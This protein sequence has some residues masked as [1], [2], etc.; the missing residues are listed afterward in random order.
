MSE[1][2]G[3]RKTDEGFIIHVSEEIGRLKEGYDYAAKGYETV[4][5]KIAEID[6]KFDRLRDA[7]YGNGPDNIGIFERI[8]SLAVRIGFILFLLA[9]VGSFLGRY[10]E[11]RMFP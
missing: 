1:N 10:L 6:Q 5:A 9:G 4:L 11:K 7:L 8:R 3:R 2:F